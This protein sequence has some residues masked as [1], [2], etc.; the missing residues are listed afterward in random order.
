MAFLWGTL[1]LPLSCTRQ[2]P[3]GISKEIAPGPTKE[4]WGVQIV[5][6]QAGS[7]VDESRN[8]LSISADYMQWVGEGDS[9]FQYLKGGHEKVEVIMY[10]SLGLQSALLQADQ[11]SYYEDRGYYIAEGGV[12]IETHENRRLKTERIKWWEH[13]KLLRTENYVHITTPDESVSGMGL[14]ASE[15]L[16]TYQIGRFSAEIKLDQ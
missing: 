2:E 5:L 8:R 16:N 6:S 15:D 10:D 9:T 11:V 12:T 1:L 4:S 14:E 3:S 13:D 7:D